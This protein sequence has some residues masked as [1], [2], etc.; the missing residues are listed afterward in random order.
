MYLVMQ[1][2]SSIR[3][4]T[5]LPSS[6]VVLCCL[7]RSRCSVKFCT[8]NKWIIL[9]LTASTWQAS[10]QRCLPP[11]HPILK[12]VLPAHPCAVYCLFYFNLILKHCMSTWVTAQPN[13]ASFDS[14]LIIMGR[15]NN[16]AYFVFKSDNVS[17]VQTHTTRSVNVA[18]FTPFSLMLPL[19]QTSRDIH[20]SW[21]HPHVNKCQWWSMNHMK[22]DKITNCL[23]SW[24]L[25]YEKESLGL[26]L[27]PTLFP[28]NILPLEL[29]G[30]RQK[31]ARFFTRPS[32]V[33]WRITPSDSLSS[34]PRSDLFVRKHSLQGINDW[35]QPQMW[36]CLS[37]R[38]SE[39][40]PNI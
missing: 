15:S 22:S 18:S 17:K 38:G 32:F 21:Q 6:P 24:P 12:H 36:F 3:A 26:N 10:C 14:E 33:C 4:R 9:C 7:A 25:F 20:S 37:W 39:F 40:Q 31:D 27:R 8:M 5:C 2:F 34:S 35:Q 30:S 1:I 29:V 28:P 11:K 23:V 13:A 16:H 19:S